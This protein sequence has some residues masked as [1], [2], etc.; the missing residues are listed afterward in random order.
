MKERHGRFHTQEPHVR[1]ASYAVGA[2]GGGHGIRCQHHYSLHL[3]LAGGVAR[4]GA[5][6]RIWRASRGQ[7]LSFAAYLSCLTI[8]HAPLS[9]RI[10]V[11]RCGTSSSAAFPFLARKQ[12]SCV[13]HVF[14]ARCPLAIV[15]PLAGYSLLLLLKLTHLELGAFVQ[16]KTR[17]GTTVVLYP[18]SR[19][20]SGERSK[21]ILL[22]FLLH[23]ST[24]TET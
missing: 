14:P 21:G 10:T 22:M 23:K 1:S 4:C 13:S 19:G 16:F 17:L 2:I 20:W 9:K 24:G 18:F 5:Q 6:G 15:R 12:T 7:A 11:P 3:E 8:D